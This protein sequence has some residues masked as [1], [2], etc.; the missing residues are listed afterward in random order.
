MMS[1]ELWGAVFRTVAPV[2]PRS[3]WSRNPGDKLHSVVKILLGKVVPEAVYVGLMSHWKNPTLLVMGV[4]EPLTLV[5]GS[6]QW[7]NIP[8]FSQ[9]L[10]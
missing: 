4:S 3:L 9:S 5:T 2:L 7:G 1:T 6:S 8:G 10:I